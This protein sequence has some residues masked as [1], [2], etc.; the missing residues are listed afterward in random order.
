[1][2]P[3]EDLELRQRL[4]QATVD[5]YNEEPASCT[6]PRAAAAAGLDLPTARRLYRT[7]GALLKGY[8]DLCLLRYRAML[9]EIDGY[10]DFD[11][12]EKLSTLVY[13]LFDLFEEERDFVEGTFEEWICRSPAKSRFQNGVEELIAETLQGTT[14]LPSGADRLL[15]PLMARQHLRLVRHWLHDE[16]PDAEETLALADKA[17]A[18]GAE[19]LQSRLWANGADLARYLLGRALPGGGLDA[20]A[21]RLRDWRR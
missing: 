14:A 2:E 1:M 15:P 11:L 7:K 16:S 9:E 5:L 3:N 21:D 10:A 6:L 17:I 4:V 20:W 13:T 18:F 19:A 8:Y 12:N